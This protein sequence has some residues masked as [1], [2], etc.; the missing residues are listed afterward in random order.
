[1]PDIMGAEQNRADSDHH[2]RETQPSANLGF[3]GYF[4]YFRLLS[5]EVLEIFVCTFWFHLSPEM[6]EEEPGRGWAG[7]CQ[8]GKHEGCVGWVCPTPPTSQTG[9]GGLPATKKVSFGLHSSG[10]ATIGDAGHLGWPACASRA[11]RLA[12]RALLGPAWCRKRSQEMSMKLAKKMSHMWFPWAKKVFD[13]KEKCEMYWN[14]RG[15]AWNA[16]PK[17]CTSGGTPRVAGIPISRTTSYELAASEGI[18][19][20]QTPAGRYASPS[21]A[22]GHGGSARREAA[23]GSQPGPCCWSPRQ[24]G[25]A[26]PE[27]AVDA[28]LTSDTDQQA[29]GGA[30]V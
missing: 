27:T 1:V 13:D 29:C 9:K 25:R 23:G 5:R 10:G 21:T 6:L 20:W 4:C 8:Q 15:Q 14:T 24:A 30:A 3:S 18:H 26:Q 7:P 16:G 28:S 17:R 2:P 12:L 11:P 19:S 22:S